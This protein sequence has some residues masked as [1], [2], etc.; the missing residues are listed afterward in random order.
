MGLA[1]AFAGAAGVLSTLG[2]VW[3]QQAAYLDGDR[4][5]HARRVRLLQPARHPFAV[6]VRRRG[7]WCLALAVLCAGAALLLRGAPLG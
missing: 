1:H 6:R 3:V 7:L 2:V 4:D 5:A